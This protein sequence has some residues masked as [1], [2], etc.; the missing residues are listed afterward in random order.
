[1]SP[2]KTITISITTRDV[3]VE[4]DYTDYCFNIILNENGCD[5]H[6]LEDAKVPTETDFLKQLIENYSSPC[7][8]KGSGLVCHNPHANINFFI[9][10]PRIR[11]ASR[12]DFFPRVISDTFRIMGQGLTEIESLICQ[13]WILKNLFYQ[14]CDF[15]EFYQEPIFTNN[16]PNLDFKKIEELIYQLFMSAQSAYSS[17]NS[18]SQNTPKAEY[19]EFI[20]YKIT[21]LFPRELIK[22]SD[23]KV[24]KLTKAN[25]FQ[26]SEANQNKSFLKDIGIFWQQDINI[27][28]I[29]PQDLPLVSKLFSSIPMQRQKEEPENLFFT[30][31]SDVFIETINKSHEKILKIIQITDYKPENILLFWMCNPQE[32]ETIAETASDV[33]CIISII[34]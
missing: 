25:P 21:D 6:W 4:S 26:V 23:T 1:M 22:L 16:K 12:R 8:L 9:Q 29:I 32:V 34:R 10:S 18:D 5:I 13:Q 24:Q 19:D 20:P 30:I 14:Q 28:K 33:S 15:D 27:N 11:S 31:S 7:Y 3:G 2:Q 17:N